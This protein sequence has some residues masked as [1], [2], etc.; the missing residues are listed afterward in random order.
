MTKIID[1]LNRWLGYLSSVV[2]GLMMLLTVC[3]VCGRYFFN[4]PIT[5][6]TEI[7][8]LMMVIIVFPALGWA[9]LGKMHVRVDILVTRFPRR[10]QAIL[11][12][13]TLLIAL[14]TYAFI[15]WRS[16][17]ESAVVNRQ[18]SLLGLP[19]TPFYWIMSVGFTTFCLAIVV[20]VIENI[21]EAVKR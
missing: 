16:F 5:G 3:D 4:H 9:A 11:G 6:T 10:V 18:T 1:F 7:S 17:L 12:A 20:L 21:T 19:F 8:R 15:T 13:I 2:L 14:S